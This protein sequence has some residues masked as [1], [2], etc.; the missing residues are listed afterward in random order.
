MLYTVPRCDLGVHLVI[1]VQSFFFSLFNCLLILGVEKIWG[2]GVIYS[3]V[4]VNVSPEITLASFR[5]LNIIV[6]ICAHLSVNMFASLI[7]YLC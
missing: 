7:S 3:Y 5:L 2:F 1:S 4:Y 6:V